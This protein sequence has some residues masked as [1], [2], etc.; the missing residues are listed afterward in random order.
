MLSSVIEPKAS[1]KSARTNKAQSRVLALILLDAVSERVRVK[2]Q[3]RVR[4]R[5]G[6]RATATLRIG[7]WFKV[8]KTLGFLRHAGLRSRL[9]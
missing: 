9:G 5:V 1:N 3:V 8:G 2:A 6:V 4:A 7:V